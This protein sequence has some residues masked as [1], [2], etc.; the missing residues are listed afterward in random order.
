MMRAV[1]KSGLFTVIGFDFTYCEYS[2]FWNQIMVG[3]K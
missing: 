3:A 1:E 2:T